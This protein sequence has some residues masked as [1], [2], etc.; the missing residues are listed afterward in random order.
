MNIT[1]S[2]L[3]D[4]EHSI[5]QLIQ[6]KEKLVFDKKEAELKHSTL[7]SKIRTGGKMHDSKYKQ[8]CDDQLKQ[9][10]KTLAIEQS[11]SDL[12]IA[13][14]AKSSLHNQLKLEFNAEQKVD[15]KQ[16][17]TELRNYYINFAADKSRVSSMRAMGAE[18]AEK[19]EVLI[20][21]LTL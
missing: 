9:R 4:L 3:T 1:H 17:L 12:N 2:T 10:K 19:I 18:F 5:N 14:R 16:K 11:I 13:I 15:V 7:K 8:I 20:V 21:S 6:Q